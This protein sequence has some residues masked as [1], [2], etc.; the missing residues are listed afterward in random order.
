V[1]IGLRLVTRLPRHEEGE[2]RGGAARLQRFVGGTQIGDDLRHSLFELLVCFALSL[3]TLGFPLF[4]PLV[5][6]ALPLSV[7]FAPLPDSSGGG[8][9]R[10]N[11]RPDAAVT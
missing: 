6:F 1:E 8:C 7:R 3:P 4:E 10:S 5:C 9:R 11:D 2:Q